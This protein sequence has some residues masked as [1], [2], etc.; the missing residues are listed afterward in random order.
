M[1]FS[2]AGYL[3]HP[4]AV[5]YKIG[6]TM[7]EKVKR[8]FSTEGLIVAAII[9]VAIFF[10]K[11]PTLYHWL[12]TPQGLWY[13]KNTSWYDAWDTN[14]QVSYLRW[15]QS[16]GLALQNTYTT[17]PH[18][19][20]FVYQ[21]YTGLGVLNR[22]LNM[23]PFVLYHI[24]SVS[25][26]VLL[27]VVCYKVVKV[28]ISDLVFQLSAFTIIALG[29]GL[30]FLP[31]F[32]FAA[33]DKIAGFTL[34][35]ALERGHDALSTL[36]LLITFT[37]IFLYYKT[38]INKY[39]FIAAL[40]GLFSMTVHPPLI[41]MYPVIAFFA[42]L[43]DF[44]KTKKRSLI[45]LPILW[46]LGGIIYYFAVLKELILSIGF[47]GMVS[48]SV[49]DADTLSL[50]LGF[51]L[52]TPF[53]FWTLISNTSDENQDLVFV[54]LFF[55]LQV[56]CLFLP[57]GFHLYYVKGMIVWA[58]I[59]GIM[60]IKFIIKG[61]KLQRIIVTA[62]VCLSLGLRLRIFGIL[63][64]PPLPNAFFFLQKPEG[65]AISFISK[66]PKGSAILSLYRIGNY[67]PAF[68]DN[69]VYYGHKY[70]TPDAE[71]TL[72]NAQYFY[73]SMN[74]DERDNFLKDN[75][76]NYIYYGLEEKEL[77][78]KLKLEVEN[79]F[80][81]HKTIYENDLATVYEVKEN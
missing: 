59:L 23:D 2:G 24:A 1:L 68:S 37:S 38:H 79:P 80:K 33:D 55:L 44:M 29:G 39:I 36:L 46:V 58:V 42:F 32:T 60:G 20:V 43:M 63:M 6:V 4:G 3:L 17:I 5:C 27:L 48:Q 76:I 69:I 15:G 72:K 7:S 14:S 53:I 30:G 74:K 21:F 16:H 61:D 67:I 31:W 81:D 28:F 64:D 52:L 56:V 71:E 57:F 8:I 26:G 13:P 47:S 50:V 40:S 51:G 77:R 78:K 54:K 70:Q 45:I 41:I 11:F 73:T 19:P 49:F 12:N 34:V 9:F 18:T 35:N 22:I 25:M 65:E 75:R 66:L 62:V 10:A